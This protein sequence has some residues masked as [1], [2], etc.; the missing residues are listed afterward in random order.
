MIQPV[1]L[2]STVAKLCSAH[3]QLVQSHTAS[4]WNF[5]VFFAQGQIKGI[6]SRYKAWLLLNLEQCNYQRRLVCWLEKFEVHGAQERKFAAR[7]GPR[8]AR[9]GLHTVN[10]LHT[11]LRLWAPMCRASVGRRFRKDKAVRSSCSK[12]RIMPYYAMF[13]RPVRDVTSC[14]GAWSNYYF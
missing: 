13:K 9:S 2:Q 1:F 14:M 4:K 12:T 10:K 8:I 6:G 7:A 5:K 11:V 3:C